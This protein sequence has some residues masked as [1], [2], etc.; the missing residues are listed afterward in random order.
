MD[1]SRPVRVAT[2]TTHSSICSIAKKKFAPFLKQCIGQWLCCMFDTDKDVRAVARQVWKG[3]FP[4]DAKRLQA[5]R[6]C[7]SSIL[8]HVHHLLAQDVQTLSD[9]RTT[10]Q[11]DAE[12]R[13]SR[14]VS[15]ALLVLA[16]VINRLELTPQSKHADKYAAI[17]GA[18]NSL[19]FWKR[20]LTIKRFPLVR[21]ACFDLLSAMCKK[22]DA[23]AQDA[24]FLIEPQLEQ[25]APIVLGCFSEN[26]S[27]VHRAMM[28]A[29]LALLNRFGEH[30]WKG[31]NAPKAVWPRL[32]QFIKT[33][34]TS[35][36]SITFP[37]LLPL[38]SMINRRILG[39]SDDRS[40]KFMSDFF[41][42][43]WQGFSSSTAASTH[44]NSSSDQSVIIRSLL[45]CVLYV[46]LHLDKY[47]TQPAKQCELSDVLVRDIACGKCIQSYLNL[48]SKTNEDTQKSFAESLKRLI[49]RIDTED[50]ERTRET[51]PHLADYIVSRAQECLN[52][53]VSNENFEMFLKKIE[54][55]CVSQEK[56][57]LSRVMDDIAWRLIISCIQSAVEKDSVQHS[58]LFLHIAREIC[59][60]I[61]IDIISSKE[62]EVPIAQQ[63]ISMAKR[64]A[65]QD[66]SESFAGITILFIEKE[67]LDVDSIKSDLIQPLFAAKNYRALH[68]ILEELFKNSNLI[69]SYTLVANYI[70]EETIKES[71]NLF[72]AK[73]SQKRTMI[74]LLTLLLSSNCPSEDNAHVRKLFNIAIES[75]ADQD[76]SS[77]Y[78]TSLEVF[79]SVLLRATENTDWRAEALFA[80]FKLGLQAPKLSTSMISLIKENPVLHRNTNEKFVAR[81]IDLLKQIL[82]GSS[83]EIVAGEIEAT[84]LFESANIL[85]ELM[86]VDNALECVWNPLIQDRA[87]WDKLQDCAVVEQE[88]Q[89]KPFIAAGYVESRFSLTRSMNG[90]A[91]SA[92]DNY[93]RYVCFVLKCLDGMQLD[94]VR[95]YMMQDDGSS[96]FAH[97][98]V[99]ADF[100]LSSTVPNE[101]PRQISFI[102]DTVLAKS[103]FN[104]TDQKCAHRVFAIVQQECNNRETSAM[105]WHS[106]LSLVRHFLSVAW[107]SLALLSNRDPLAAYS[108]RQLFRI[109]CTEMMFSKPLDKMLHSRSD[110]QT[111]AAIAQSMCGFHSLLGDSKAME[112]MVTV[113]RKYL[114]TDG[115]SQR[116]IDTTKDWLLQILDVVVQRSNATADEED[117]NDGIDDSMLFSLAAAIFNIYLTFV[118]PLP[119][120]GSTEVY[121][122]NKSDIDIDS[123]LEMLKDFTLGKILCSNEYLEKGIEVDVAEVLS[124]ISSSGIEKLFVDDESTESLHEFIANFVEQYIAR[125][126]STIDSLQSGLIGLTHSGVVAQ[127]ETFPIVVKLCSH[128]LLAEDGT[129]H[130]TSQREEEESLMRLRSIVG[131][132]VHVF[133]L[134][135]DGASESEAENKKDIVPTISVELFD[136]MLAEI[137]KM[138]IH[139]SDRAKMQ[140]AHAIDQF[141]LDTSFD[142]LICL[143]NGM[144]HCNSFDENDTYIQLMRYNLAVG[145]VSPNNSAK[146]VRERLRKLL[147]IEHHTVIVGDPEDGFS[148]EEVRFHLHSALYSLLDQSPFVTKDD[149]A[150]LTT[151]KVLQFVPANSVVVDSNYAR[152][153]MLVWLFVANLHSALQRDGVLQE[154]DNDLRKA[155]FGLFKA[156]RRLV[157]NVLDASFSYLLQPFAARL[158]GTNAGMQ[159]HYH[160]EEDM[161]HD[162][163][164]TTNLLTELQ[165]RVVTAEDM[166]REDSPERML[167]CQTLAGMV[168]HTMTNQFP[169]LV[170]SW[171]KQLTD[172]PL[173]SMVEQYCVRE[174]CTSIIAQELSAIDAWAATLPEHITVK[175]S[176]QTRN[177]LALYEQDEIKLD[178]QLTIPETYPFKTL[179]IESS[180]RL[181]VS[182]GEWRRFLMRMTTSIFSSQSGGSICS[183]IQLWKDNLDKR[184]EGRDP[185]PICYSVLAPDHSMPEHECSVCRHKLH[186][187]C[188]Y[189]WFRSSANATCPV[190][191]SSNSFG[192]SR[193]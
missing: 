176:H 138:L 177:V 7:E 121:V 187:A 27:Q 124:N 31:I 144:R 59:R 17:C 54:M 168:V 131:H 74:S 164:V 113:I 119:A 155:V 122:V 81:C 171:Y 158:H 79:I 150:P 143:F 66:M 134:L 35:S 28:D 189:K 174:I 110:I 9:M 65:T 80:I 96:W 120:D 166:N 84:S 51:V 137:A 183:C 83:L 1:T 75:L 146:C 2:F 52:N 38:L 135:H 125:L 85:A 106:T 3:T 46:L 148:Q 76:I 154:Q 142:F 181:G 10:T 178:V 147:A 30:C 157:K 36:P 98:I 165:S 172:G 23:V 170:R 94:I 62:V 129:V 163:D 40:I 25:I 188:L 5:L 140:L 89:G 128:T 14:V 87:L 136:R 160:R 13:F 90:R 175:T 39:D 61:P 123:C 118:S 173:L 109:L 108:I 44:V 29:L 78:A 99:R 86:G 15:S 193:K 141:D 4:D 105:T 43:M 149:T 191:R 185:C 132:L 111:A 69:E 18:S 58:E 33:P 71:H 153:Y 161:D 42:N 91:T 72:Q 103:M 6:F 167:D 102:R 24:S 190:C 55:L 112:T 101:Y 73:E 114:G 19:Q 88:E 37:S 116:L 182:E 53:V 12:E 139:S 41:N 162:D 34:Q 107:Q 49:T 57:S 82:A 8:D 115:T 104:V 156:N 77:E 21:S 45:E 151:R 63:L 92:L 186:V 184:F 180:R 145:S 50:S 11:S 70:I 192:Y 64:H 169:S 95:D 130:N 133:K 48:E 159:W 32:W 100:I 47:C 152:V 68:T 16:F 20:F 93:V 126:L 56:R 60:H 67:R 179:S 22:A 26:E 97:S 127:F 117:E